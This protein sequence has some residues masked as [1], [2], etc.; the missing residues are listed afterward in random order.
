MNCSSEIKSY[1]QKNMQKE[2]AKLTKDIDEIKVLQIKKTELD[3][4]VNQIPVNVINNEQLKKYILAKLTADLKTVNT[5]INKLDDL[6]NLK[7]K[8]D[9]FIQQIV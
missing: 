6:T 4:L 2:L 9:G 8:L 5:K 1:T 3:I 7:A